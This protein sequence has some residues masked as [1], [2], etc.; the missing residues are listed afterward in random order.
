MY[1][2]V[3]CLYP[4]NLSDRPILCSGTQE[5]PKVAVARMESKLEDAKKRV[6]EGEKQIKEAFNIHIPLSCTYLSEYGYRS[7]SSLCLMSVVLS[8]DGGLQEWAEDGLQDLHT[9]QALG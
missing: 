3:T 2:K 9:I 6:I 7:V 4:A 5:D 8:G 1:V